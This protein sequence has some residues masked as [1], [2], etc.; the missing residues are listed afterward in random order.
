VGLLGLPAIAGIVLLFGILR[1]ELTLVML[2]TLIVPIVGSSDFSKI[3][4]PIQMVVFA[5]VVMFYVPCI[6]TL[7][8]LV[9]EIGLKRTSVIVIIEL[10]LALLVGAIAFRVLGLLV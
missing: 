6:A 5:L 8:V 7:A 2:A 3:M 1:K 10:L 9:R 4:D